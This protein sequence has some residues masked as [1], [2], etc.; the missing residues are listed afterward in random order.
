MK[1]L[2][3]IFV[4]LT[5][6]LLL[7]AASCSRRTVPADAVHGSS[8]QSAGDVFIKT[9]KFTLIIPDVSISQ[10]EIKR[11]EQFIN[12][13]IGR[14][15]ASGTATPEDIIETARGYLGVPH[16]MGGTTAKCMDC[17]GLIFRVFATYGILLPHNSEEQAR[18]GRIIAE[19]EMLMPGDLVFF[20]RTYSSS[21]LI[22][23]SGIFIGE[24]RFIHTSSSQGVTTT[25]LNDPY[26]KERYLFGTRIFE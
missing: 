7:L 6:I 11:L 24:D 3:P 10:S 14:S 13:G 21:W 22:T 23:H 17:S 1:E 26:W 9:P 20:V 18:Y 25:P 8:G 19:K 15:V 2:R 4:F 5:I 12:A 16:C